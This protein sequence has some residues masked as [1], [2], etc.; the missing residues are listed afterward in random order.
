MYSLLS[1]RVFNGFH[2]QNRRSSRL[3]L[4]H[5]GLSLPQ[6]F[7]SGGPDGSVLSFASSS[8]TFAPKGQLP[9]DAA[10]AGNIGIL[11]VLL[12]G[13]VNFSVF[14]LLGILRAHS[15]KGLQ[16]MLFLKSL[17]LFSFCGNLNK[18]TP[19]DVRAC[20][21]CNIVFHASDQK[22]LLSQRRRDHLCK[23]HPHE[24]IPSMTI[25]VNKL[26]SSLRLKTFRLNRLLGNVP[27]VP[28]VFSLGKWDHDKA[29][30]R[31]YRTKQPRRDT[32]RKA[33]P[34][35]RAKLLRSQKREAQKQ[36]VSLR[37]RKRN[38]LI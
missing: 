19:K 1:Q 8:E 29:V 34:T 38:L 12:S 9:V 27:S 28:V 3:S 17:L 4:G 13:L 32:S 37:C 2:S 10:I 7:I 15:G 23:R 21:Y 36:V 33:V 6:S 30:R 24:L 5:N 20:P 11:A 18:R 22:I 14:T 35:A 26:L 31:H 16:K 25:Y